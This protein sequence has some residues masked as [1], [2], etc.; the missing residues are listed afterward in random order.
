MFSSTGLIAFRLP[1]AKMG[2]PSNG[3]YIIQGELSLVVT[4]MRRSSRWA[5]HAQRDD[6]GDPLFSSFSQLKDILNNVTGR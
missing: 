1:V 6:D 5:S 2:S 4:A 3:I